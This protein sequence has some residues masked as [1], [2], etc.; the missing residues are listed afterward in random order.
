MKDITK[1]NVVIV[2]SSISAAKDLTNSFNNKNFDVNVILKEE[3]DD[4]SINSYKCE[5]NDTMKMKEI[6]NNF[7]K[8]DVL[9]IF[10]SSY[11]PKTICETTVE[12]FDHYS[13][14]I[15][16]QTYNAIKYALPAIRRSQGNIIILNSSV[17]INCEPGATIYSMIQST[18]I[19]LGK[20][21]AIREGKNGVRV[22]NI[23]LGPART[24]ELMKKV[25]DEQIDEWKNINPLGVSFEF[26]DFLNII[27]DIADGKG[28]YSKMTGTVIP[29][30]GGESIADE[31]TS[32]QKGG[33]LQ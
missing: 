20:A 16:K 11:L 24:D 27:V 1:K 6:F 33:E 19:M 32:T 3:F 2:T 12:D 30:D 18:L 4:K 25:S 23:A 31:Y 26:S 15:I 28:G 22:N 29:I 5:I 21:L 8:I 9:I 10:P 14:L 7:D 13:N 17:A